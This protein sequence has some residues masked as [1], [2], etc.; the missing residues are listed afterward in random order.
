[1]YAFRVVK[2]R[3]NI[4]TRRH[5]RNGTINYFAL[6]ETFMKLFNNFKNTV[7][8]NNREQK[9]NLNGPFELYKIDFRRNYRNNI[10]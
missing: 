7:H 5:F 6:Q 9:K 4:F 8:F 10:E 2:K 1:M 3:S